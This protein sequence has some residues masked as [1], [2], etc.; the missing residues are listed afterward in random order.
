VPD[1]QSK[2]RSG[3][4]RGR[5]AAKPQQIPAVGWKDV[6]WRSWR[7]VSD[8]NIFLISGGV[9]YAILLALFPGLAALVS[10]YGLFQNPS[11][12]ETQVSALA[13][14]LPEQ[15][16]QLLAS[17]LHQLAEA[18]GSALGFSAILGLLVAFWS[19]SR[20]MSGL[21]TALDIAYEER[22]ERS[23]FHLNLVALT[24]TLG[25]VFGGIVAITLIAVLPAAVQLLGLDPTTKWILLVLEWPLLVG[26][27]MVGLAVLYRF[28]PDRDAPQW[29]WVSPGAITA[30]ILWILAS[31]A[32]TIY[33]ANFNSYDKTYGSLGGAII[34]LTW[35]Y[36]SSFVV[37]LGGV[38][39]AQS[40]R[41][42]R[43]DTTRGKPEPMGRRDAYAADTVGPSTRR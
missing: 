34:L 24:L 18:S 43:K 17:Q 14:V 29:R 4:A 16:Q 28:A 8:N 20:G 36:L 25:A 37:L 32:F 3:S 11:Q 40:E 2:D 23:F 27:V 6:L 42:T 30:T 38:I 5:E 22:E 12:I 9:T 31:V 41:Q 15:S 19:A 10:L 33:V 13:G 35:L 7:E 26:L 21:I 1:D 39:N